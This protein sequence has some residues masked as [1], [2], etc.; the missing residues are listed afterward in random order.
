[1]RGRGMC[2]VG[3]CMTGACVVGDMHGMCGRGKCM[4][5][6]TC[7]ARGCAWQGA[8]VAE[9]MYGKEGMC[10]KGGVHG[11][12]SMWGKGACVAGEMAAAADG[13]HSTGMH[14]C[15]NLFPLE[16]VQKANVA[17]CLFFNKTRLAERSTASSNIVLCVV[18]KCNQGFID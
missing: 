16:A 6:G 5:R 3:V 10:G 4:A 12:G 2:M 8:C 18:F 13:M 15:L 17:N 11:K 14:S 1:M 9:G 7:V